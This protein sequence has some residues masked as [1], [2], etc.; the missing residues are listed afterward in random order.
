MNYKQINLGNIEKFLI[1]EK[2][3]LLHIFIIIGELSLCQIRFAS[4]D[5]II[6]SNI[7]LVEFFF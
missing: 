5:P 1:E 2:T 4:R 6:M 7:D 3:L